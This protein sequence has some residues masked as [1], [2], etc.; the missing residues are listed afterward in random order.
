MRNLYL[1]N[2]FQVKSNECEI[3]GEP[4]RLQ[5]VDFLLTDPS[6]ITKYFFF[7]TGR[8][9]YFDV[10]KESDVWKLSFWSIS[11]KDHLLHHTRP[12]NSYTPRDTY[13][14]INIYKPHPYAHRKLL[15]VS[16][17]NSGHQLTPTG[18]PRHTKRL[19]KVVWRLMLTSNGICWCL[20]VSNSILQ[21]P[22]V[23]GNVRRVSEEFIKGCLIAV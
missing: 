22:M 15:Q 6:A 20:L 5:N 2:I 3:Q 9:L 12:K 14:P 1:Y 11:N 4:K 7:N 23:L 16:P 17:D 8:F 10:S 18:G 21:C 19:F 13:S